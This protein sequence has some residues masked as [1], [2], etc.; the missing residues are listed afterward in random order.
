MLPDENINRVTQNLK[1]LQA[2]HLVQR[3]TQNLYYVRPPDDSRA[4]EPLRPPVD[5]DW[6]RRALLLRAAS[7]F[8][9]RRRPEAEVKGLADLTAEFAEIGLLIQAEEFEAA[10]RAVENVDD[11]LENWGCRWILRRHREQLSGLL[12]D[13]LYEL[14]NLQALG[15]IALHTDDLA[16]AESYYRQ[17]ISYLEVCNWLDVRKMLYVSLGAVLQRRDDMARAEDKYREALA[18][19]REHGE[20]YAEIVPLAGLADCHRHRGELD[21]AVARLEAA[22]ELA[23]AQVRDEPNRASRR[24]L[25]EIMVKLGKRY[26]ELGEFERAETVLAKAD[27]HANQ[28]DSWVTRCLHLDAAANLKL[29]QHRL[30]EAREL[31]QNGLEL[32]LSLGRAPLRR[33]V[34]TT[35]AMCSLLEDELDEAAQHLRSATRDRLPGHALR[36]LALNG[37]LEHR[38]NHRWPAQR[39]FRQLR[40]EAAERSRRDHLDFGALD[41]E[42]LARCGEHVGRGEQPLDAAIAVFRQARRVTRAPGI[43]GQMV[44]LLTLFHDTRLQPAIAAVIGT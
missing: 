35:L 9:L 17:A 7:Y 25:A 21:D 42:G 27:V 6:D 32:A 22:M 1:H 41:M 12:R 39:L 14:V 8:G 4:L 20:N 44:Q 43:T 13:E 24:Q 11:Y 37:V 36:T 31:G 23:E 40:L 10:F 30:R 15:D 26:T 19:A 34:C 3:T 38:Q 28:I 5:D 16:T 33:Q 18:I 2:S 29:S